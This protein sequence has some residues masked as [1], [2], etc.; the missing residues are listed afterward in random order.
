MTFCTDNRQ[1]A[2]CLHFRTQLDIGTTTCHVGSN[3]HR[4]ALTGFRNDFGFLLVQFRIQY[5]V[6]NLTQ[7][8]HLAQHFGYFYRCRTY[9]YRTTCIDHLLDFLDNRLV[10]F[11]FGLIDTIVHI[12]TGNRTIGRDNHYIQFIDVPKLAR[13]GFRRTGHTGELMI[14]TE[15]VLQS[16]CSKCLRSGFNLHAFLGFYRLMQSVTPTAS[17]HDTSGLLV[18]NLHLT[19][20]NDIVG[21]LFEHRI[22]LQQLVDGVYTFCFNSIVGHELVFLGKPVFIAQPFFVF[23]CG[24]LCGDIRQYKQSRV[25]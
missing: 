13:F 22:S 23:Q 19:V 5:I 2:C 7:G 17:F 6:R 18:N 16:D 20:H 1:T 10:L 11:T 4:T 14:H 25:L 24:K 8:K 12:N 21:I 15:I 3:G 9:Q